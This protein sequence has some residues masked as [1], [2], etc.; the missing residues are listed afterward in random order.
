MTDDFT[1]P[2]VKTVTLLIEQYHYA[3]LFDWPFSERPRYDL[4]FVIERGSA[5]ALHALQDVLVQREC[6]ASY[7]KDWWQALKARFA[8]KWALRRWPVRENVIDMTVLYPRIQL[9]RERHTAKM[10]VRYWNAD[11]V[12]PTYSR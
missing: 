12:L 10:D 9:P 8:P 1:M 3:H 2:D 4:R 7:P 5:I 11:R 6:V